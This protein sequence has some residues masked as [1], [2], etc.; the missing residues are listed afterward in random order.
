MDGGRSGGER[1][2]AKRDTGVFFFGE[3]VFGDGRGGGAEDGGDVLGGLGVL[4]EKTGESES[5]I[6]RIIVL[7]IRRIVGFVDDDKTEI[8]SWGENSRTGADNEAGS[9][10]LEDGFP[11]LVAGGGGEFGVEKEEVF[12]EE[13]LEKLAGL[14]C[15][16][17]FWDKKEG[18]S[19]VF[20][21]IGDEVE[22]EMGFTA[23]GDAV[24]KFSGGF[25]VV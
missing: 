17:D 14:G 18:G 7:I 2:L 25:E 22:V 12:F 3:V 5:G 21:G 23:A 4:G 1:S 13:A 20:K 9:G 15:E 11:G 10:F 19:L 24:E 8:F 6:A 16:A